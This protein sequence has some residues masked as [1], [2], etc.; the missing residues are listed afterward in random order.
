MERFDVVLELKCTE[1]KEEWISL[2]RL[3]RSVARAGVSGGSRRR[4]NKETEES[5]EPRTR[6]PPRAIRAPF[7]PRRRGLPSPPSLW[8]L[9]STSFARYLVGQLE[10]S[11]SLWPL[12]SVHLVRTHRRTSIQAI[13]VVLCLSRVRTATRPFRESNP[14]V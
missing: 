4:S 9:L 13:H 8:A 10:S 6:R 11:G 14:Q 2:S 5:C 1:Q 7:S 3:N 12:I